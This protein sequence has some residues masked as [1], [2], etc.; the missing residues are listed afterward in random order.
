MT[1]PRAESTI[2]ETITDPSS[3]SGAGTALGDLLV[4]DLTR[5]LSGPFATMTLAD[6]GADVIKIEQPGTGDDTRQWGPPFQGDEAAYFLSV[7]RNKRSLA[8]DLKSPEGL[9]AVR[10]L[11]LKADVVVE[12]FRPGT[13]ARLGLGY[14]ELSRDNPGLVY[15]SI[16]GYGQ[17]GPDAHRP[18][19][20]AIAQARSGIMSVTGEAD[21]P[22]VRVGV[23][24]ADLVAGMWATIGI[25]AALHEKQRTGKGQWVD[26]SLL[27]GSVSWLTYVSSGYFASGDIPQR[28][29]SAHPTIAPYQAFATSDGFVMV[30]V[31]NDGLWLKFATAIGRTDLAE[32]PRFATNPSRVAHRGTL[33]PFLEDVMRTRTAAEWV[34]TLD[35]AGVPVGPIQTV[36]QALQDPQVLARGMVTELVHP[37]AGPMKVV[38]CPVRLT[39]TPPSVRTAPPMLGQDTGDVLAELGFSQDRI[40]LLRTNGVVQ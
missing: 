19:Y 12:N 25:L 35:S 34:A 21:G 29:G 28:Y 1:L 11:A 13:A 30:A 20:D 31:G 17:T 5:I 9:A 38:G 15:A 40:R 7:N 16:S 26:I 10:E 32:D 37:A 36:D 6:L 3:V 27:D 2:N 23:S 14:E 22:P 39:R 24:S 33:I 18:G 8:V 4:L